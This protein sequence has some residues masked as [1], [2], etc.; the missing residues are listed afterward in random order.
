MYEIKFNPIEP[1]KIYLN[2]A[3]FVR[4]DKP[5]VD[6]SACYDFSASHDLWEYKTA[7]GVFFDFYGR[8]FVDKSEITSFAMNFL[9]KSGLQKKRTGKERLY[10]VPPLHS[11]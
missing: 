1:N 4:A 11:M 5:A 2:G 7:A 10:F 6:L 3:L 9:A 8:S